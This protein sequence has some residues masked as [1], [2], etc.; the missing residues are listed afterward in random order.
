LWE[1]EKAVWVT[2]IC[3]G[4]AT[5]FAWGSSGGKNCLKFEARTDRARA[6]SQGIASRTSM[7]GRDRSCNA[8]LNPVDFA[9]AGLRLRRKRWCI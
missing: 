6:R 2:T 1:E 7:G 3:P 9:H 5:H 8:D 4:S